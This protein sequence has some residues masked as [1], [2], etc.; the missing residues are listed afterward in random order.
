MPAGQGWYDLYS[1]KFYEGGQTITS[2]AD[3][4]RT[5][6]FIKAGSI[7]PTGPALQY[8]SEK[9]ADPLTLFIYTGKDAS[10][11]LYEDEGVNYNYEKGK[12]TEIPITY[13]Q[14]T[15]TLTIGDRSG[16]FAGMLNSRTIYIKVIS[17]LQAL[18]FAFDGKDTGR[19]VEYKG[20]KVVI[21]L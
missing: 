1:G 20:K 8:T 5:P 14:A 11:T 15:N 4:E 9:A 7:I 17:A 13:N 12:F 21:R 6:V 2:A 10:F 18:P 16:S 3:Y 19:K